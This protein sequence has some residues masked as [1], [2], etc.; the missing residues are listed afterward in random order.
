MQCTDKEKIYNMASTS[1]FKD[2]A[3]SLHCL[4]TNA[5][6]SIIF[7]LNSQLESD[8]KRALLVVKVFATY[9]SESVCYSMLQQFPPSSILGLKCWTGVQPQISRTG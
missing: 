9:T 4:V 2:D 5:S 1:G 6:S 8:N 3:V 7:A